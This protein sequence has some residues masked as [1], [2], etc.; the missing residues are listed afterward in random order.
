[1]A[2]EKRERVFF[3]YHEFVA[4]GEPILVSGLNTRQQD[5]KPPLDLVINHFPN[6]YVPQG[7]PVYERTRIVRIPRA[8]DSHPDSVR[9]PQ[10]SLYTPGKEPLSL[11]STDNTSAYSMHDGYMYGT[12]SMTPLVPLL[13]S[14]AELLEIV[15][16]VNSLFQRVFPPMGWVSAMTSVADFLTGSLFSAVLRGLGRNGADAL[17]ELEEYTECVNLRFSGRHRDLKMVSLRESGFLSLDFQ[18]PLTR[19]PDRWS[20]LPGSEDGRTNLEG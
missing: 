12:T 20:R 13:L 19:Q 7:S 11:V 14:E 16:N 2:S 5:A 1:M 15:R 10:F 8:Y 3:N 4:H 9:I 6:V 17:A 18:I